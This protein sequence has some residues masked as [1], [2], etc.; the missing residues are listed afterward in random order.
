[1][2]FFK[3]INNKSIVF[4]LLDIAGYTYGPLLGL[5]AFGILT[6]RQIN[7]RAS[8][9]VCIGA[10]LLV[11]G[12]DMLNNAEWFIN[13]L[14]FEKS[15]ADTLKNMA[16]RL[17]RADSAEPKSIDEIRAYGVNIQPCKKGKD[18]VRNG[19]Q[20]IQNQSISITS[21]SVNG[22]KEYRNYLWMADKNGQ[23]VTPNE[24]EKGNDHFL[25][26]ARYAL[27]T[28]GR[29]KQEVGYWDKIFDEEL[30][31]QRKKILFNKG[32]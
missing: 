5:F 26:A 10:P 23:V 15:T 11:L 7:D 8:L 16:E 19:I 17:V 20:L 27:E 9:W 25:D 29:I 24:P 12:V 30:T 3:W 28:L 22:I 14:S 6:K 13:K 2:L 1:V 18:S 4:I 32:R 31:G 21:R